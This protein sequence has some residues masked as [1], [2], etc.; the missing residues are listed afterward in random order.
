MET[1][2]L[3]QEE[4]PEKPLDY[5]PFGLIGIVVALLLAR[6]YKWSM[7]WSGLLGFGILSGIGMAIRAYVN[8]P[9]K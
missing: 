6:H 5:I 2:I 1:N 4:Q 3:I 8:P 7:F 9:S